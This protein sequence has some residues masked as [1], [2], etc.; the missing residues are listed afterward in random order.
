MRR[1]SAA[2]AAL[3]LVLPVPATSIC[4]GSPGPSVS[5][6]RLISVTGV[7]QP[8]DG[9]PPPAGTVVT[10]VDLR[11]ARRAA[12]RCGRKRRTSPST[13]RAASRC[14][15]GRRNPTASRSRSL[16][17]ATRSGSACRSLGVGEAERPRTRITS[18]PYALRVVGCR[19]ARR[20]AGVRV[21][22]RLRH[23][24]RWPHRHGR[25]S[26][27]YHHRH[28]VYQFDVR[29]RGASR[30]GQRHREVRQQCRRRA[31]RAVRRRAGPWASTPR[32]PSTPCTSASPT[33]GAA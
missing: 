30:H 11:R 1:M 19:H 33:P 17:R 13:R 10:L 28:G 15:S 6:P 16:P 18:V 20:P 21:S 5:V 8:A 29:R 31:V 25:Q 3:L 9:Q 2:F 14:S 26:G 24:R 32:R 23:R 7:Y 22:A 12:P 27:G 4:A